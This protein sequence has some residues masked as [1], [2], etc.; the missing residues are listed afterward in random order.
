MLDQ[1]FEECVDV[2]EQAVDIDSVRCI[3]W[4]SMT[5][6]IN[7]DFIFL[8]SISSLTHVATPPPRFIDS[9]FLTQNFGL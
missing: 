6:S 9:P 1:V 2:S 4:V 3:V 5:F 8:K 7:G